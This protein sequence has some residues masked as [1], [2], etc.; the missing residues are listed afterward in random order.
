MAA[1]S[2]AGRGS[3]VGRRREGLE[4]CQRAAEAAEADSHQ[5]AG[6]ER[7][8]MP[9]DTSAGEV[10]GRDAERHG[11]IDRR[12]FGQ[13]DAEASRGK[14]TASAIAEDRFSGG[15][16]PGDLHVAYQSVPLMK[17]AGDLLVACRSGLLKAAGVASGQEDEGAGEKSDH[18]HGDEPCKRGMPASP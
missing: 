12:S 18:N 5:V 6:S 2:T 15:A 3:L 14:I 16:I 10:Q 4:A 13:F 8:G 7:A 1:N 11:S 17:A 9:D